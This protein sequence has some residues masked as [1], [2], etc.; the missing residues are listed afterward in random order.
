MLATLPAV[1]GTTTG[2]IIS[3]Q[4]KALILVKR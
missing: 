1:A 2:I 3:V 4:L